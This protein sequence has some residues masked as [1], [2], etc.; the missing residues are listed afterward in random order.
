[1]KTWNPVTIIKTM[2]ARYKYK[3][4]LKAK[5]KAAKEKDPYIY[6]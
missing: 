4:T 3:K 2:I 5:L 6:D 1:M